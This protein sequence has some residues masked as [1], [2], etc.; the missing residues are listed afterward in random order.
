MEKLLIYFDGASQGNPG[1]AAI[2]VVITD[3]RGNV[4]EEIS[5]PIGRATNNVAEYR[6]LIEAARAALEYMPQRAIFFTD[7]QLVAN[8]INGIYR[9]RQPHLD[10]LNREAEDLL[11][12]FPQWQVRYI[13]RT[14]NWQAH[15]LAQRAL[16]ERGAS[17]EGPRSAQS[18]VERLCA[19][20][21]R[22]PEDDQRK[23]LQ[24]ARRLL[25]DAEEED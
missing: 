15:R 22:L 18:T 13:E 16:I 7:S 21:E 20:A 3:G 24:Y 25:Q 10:I 9:V 23:L 2:G 19:I 8:Q 12:R 11:Q 6:A 4:I 17:A 14:A 5:K 1:D